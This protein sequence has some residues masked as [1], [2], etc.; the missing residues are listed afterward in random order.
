MPRDVEVRVRAVDAREVEHV[1]AGRIVPRTTDSVPIFLERD[2][3]TGRRQGAGLPPD[4]RDRRDSPG[5]EIQELD[6]DQRIRLDRENRN[7]HGTSLRG[8][9]LRLPHAL[10]LPLEL[11]ARRLRVEENRKAFV[12][13]CV[14]HEL[15]TVAVET[16]DRAHHEE[17]RMD[18]TAPAP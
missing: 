1:D 12:A 10:L 6:V 5:E 18:L 8:R 9:R 2:A 13:T 4:P 14:A 16:R 17:L 15:A 11:G 3:V 7:R